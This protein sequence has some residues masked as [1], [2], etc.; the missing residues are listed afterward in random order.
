MRTK[1]CKPFTVYITVRV[2]YCCKDE[3]SPS[4]LVY[5]WNTTNKIRPVKEN[6]RKARRKDTDLKGP[7][8]E[9][10]RN[11]WKGHKRHVT[12]KI[13]TSRVFS[14]GKLYRQ[15]LRMYSISINSLLFITLYLGGQFGLLFFHSSVTD[16]R[17]DLIDSGNLQIWRVAKIFVISQNHKNYDIS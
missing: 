11:F 9:I 1:M 14:T 6:S 5:I 10:S 15:H 3:F 8:Y 17:D 16:L 12:S 4:Y 13:C 2:Q 7:N